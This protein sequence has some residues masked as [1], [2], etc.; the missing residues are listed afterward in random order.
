MAAT[1]AA[2]VLGRLSAIKANAVQWFVEEMVSFSGDDPGDGRLRH[3]AHMLPKFRLDPRQTLQAEQ[4]MLD[5]FWQ[6]RDRP[7]KA[8]A[9]RSL[10][11]FARVNF[12]LREFAEPVVYEVMRISRSG[13]VVREA[14]RTLD[15]I[16]YFQ[17]SVGEMLERQAAHA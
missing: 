16:E 4:L 5:L 1:R 12:L 8:I 7:L 15:A 13:A 14:E 3:V 11:H 9:L 2:Y 10:R 6:E 17:E